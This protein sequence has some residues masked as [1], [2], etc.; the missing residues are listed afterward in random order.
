MRRKA[1][2][3]PRSDESK[4]AIEQSQD[5]HGDLEQKRRMLVLRHLELWNLQC[6]RKRPRALAIWQR[7]FSRRATPLP[8]RLE[9]SVAPNI[10]VS[11]SL[12]TEKFPYKW[13]AALPEAVLREIQMYSQEGR[14]MRLDDRVK[15]L[16]ASSQEQEQREEEKEWPRYAIADL[17]S[18]VRNAKGITDS[19]G[20]PSQLLFHAMEMEALLARIEE[21]ARVTNRKY[22]ARLSA[23]LRDVCRVHDPSTFSRE[24][25]ERLKG[26]VTALAEGWGRLTREK[27]KY[28]R[29]RLLDE[30]L[31]WLP[32]TDKALADLGEAQKQ[33]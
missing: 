8:G 19:V 31:T 9:R 13:L 30:G 2:A 17:H 20:D 28:V 21:K 11:F 15:L 5:R 33:K 26:S 1:D 18:L 27:L 16:D 24:Q 10:F 6:R 3:Q 29:T 22:E 12:K 23:S 25:A 7:L 14:G 32:V 4:R